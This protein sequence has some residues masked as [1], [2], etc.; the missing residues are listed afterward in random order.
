MNWPIERCRIEKWCVWSFNLPVFKFLLSVS[1]AKISL[2]FHRFKMRIIIIYEWKSITDHLMVSLHC[3]QIDWISS[4]VLFNFSFSPHQFSNEMA[5]WKIRMKINIGVTL[6]IHLHLNENFC[7][8]TNTWL[9][10]NI[11][12]WQLAFKFISILST[13]YVTYATSI[14]ISIPKSMFPSSKN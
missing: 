7:I 4:C 1:S 12:H 3:I 2:F 11:K 9:G 5:E 6:A 14:I 8:A 13:P 10:I